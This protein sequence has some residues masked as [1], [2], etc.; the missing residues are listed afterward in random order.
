MYII[1]DKGDHYEI[2]KCHFAFRE[3]FKFFKKNPMIFTIM[4]RGAYPI[5]N[6]PVYG[7]YHFDSIKEDQF[8]VV[9]Q[10]MNLMGDWETLDYTPKPN[11]IRE[12]PNTYRQAVFLI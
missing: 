11:I 9:W 8:K 4:S 12:N 6:P 7:M 2:R 3:K 10:Y 1:Y 5:I